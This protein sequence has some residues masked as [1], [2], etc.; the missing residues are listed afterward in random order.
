ML[1]LRAFI[2]VSV[3]FLS[4]AEISRAELPG[5]FS[6]I[7]LESDQATMSMVR[8]ALH[9][10]SITAIREVGVEDGSALVMTTSR[11]AGAPTPD[12]DRWTIY[13][14]SLKTGKSQVLVSGYGIKLIDWIGQAHD[15]LA[16]TFDNCWEC[17]PSTVFTT[18]HFTKG[19]G[20][21]AR[22]PNKPHDPRYPEPG[23]T[24]LMTGVGPPYDDDV[25]EQ[26]FAVVRLPNNG[27]AA[28]S[29][30]RWHY[31][32]IGKTEDDVERYSIDPATHEDRVEKLGGQAALKW[33]REICAESN[34]L[35]QPSVGQNSRRC[36]AVLRSSVPRSNDAK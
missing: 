32:D 28:G 30:V 18:L 17:E 2:F 26:V 22:W 13:D 5:G 19:L 34:I 14:I 3:L 33:E 10:S 23:A 29:W 6:W 12:Y 20:W 25:V 4:V 21:R 7:D 1:K 16:I 8:H 27:F 9:D 36:R 15:E 11:E 24:V 35:I 31:A